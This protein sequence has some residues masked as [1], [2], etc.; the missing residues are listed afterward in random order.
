MRYTRRS[1]IWTLSLP[2]FAVL[3]GW[4][5]S[6]DEGVLA[7]DGE[8]GAVQAFMADEPE[9]E[10][11]RTARSSEGAHDPQSV[12]AQGSYSGSLDA[13]AQ[14]SISADGETWVDLGSP[15]Q[16]S[17]DLQTTGGQS[18]LHGE[19]Q[20]PADTYSHVRLVLEDARANLDTGSTIGA[21]LVD[22]GLTIQL[23]T[24]GRVTIEKT[25]PAF[26]VSA[27]S[28]TDIH[29]NMNSDR[30]I[31]EENAAEEI[32]DEEEVAAAAEAEA[33]TRAESQF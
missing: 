11:V 12:S 28:R 31:T 8:T 14:V 32:A 7:P 13:R 20:V 29:W 3:A 9:G 22:L 5:C 4:G 10:A 27:E 25:V 17:V 18:N 23:G 16:A 26:Q 30:W 2:L 21:I 24:Q 19:V 6:D 15:T 33:E 1:S